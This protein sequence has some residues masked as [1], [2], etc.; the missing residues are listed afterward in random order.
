MTPA[1]IV[2]RFASPAYVYQ[3]EAVRA[4]HAA[5]S[6]ALPQPSGLYYSLKANPHPMVVAELIRLG[7]LA[8]VS[9]LGELKQALKA[10]AHP[11]SCMFTG[12]GKTEFDLRE[13]FRCGCRRFSVDSPWDL[14]KVERH[15]RAAEVRAEVLLRINPDLS[16]PGMG[17]AMC[18]TPSQFGVDLRWILDEPQAFS[19]G[20]FVDFLGFHFYM[21]TNLSAPE[22]IIHA[23][24]VALEA[25][26]ELAG[27]GF[28]PK[29]LDLGGGFGHPFAKSGN[30]PDL[31]ALRAPIEALLDQMFPRWRIGSPMVMFESGRYLV[32]SSGRLLTTVQDVKISKGVSFAVLD[33]GINHLGGMAGLRRVANVGVQLNQDP[34]RDPGTET[35]MDLVGPLCTPLDFLARRTVMPKPSR[36]DV[37]EISNVGAYGLTASLIAFLGHDTPTEIVLDGDNVVDV[38]R[39]TIR[40][41]PTLRGELDDTRNDTGRIGEAA[42]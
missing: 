30:R 26:S 22:T 10:G 14:E 32:A 39:L 33:A 11:S 3:L 15:A 34:T 2:D 25:A 6:R 42:S 31:S 37:L 28:I 9:S 5:L 27:R 41:Q 20:P 7:C 21:G 18:G 35:E 40:R 8:E 17:L 12:P 38:S 1:D 13:A 29:V 4:S 23:T 16:V 36:G 19:R 24:K